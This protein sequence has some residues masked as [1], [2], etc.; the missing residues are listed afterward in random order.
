VGRGS[1]DPACV[2]ME[3]DIEPASSIREAGDEE[4][5]DRSGWVWEPETGEE[6]TSVEGPAGG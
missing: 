2:V 6:E 3:L 1:I 5:E 4:A